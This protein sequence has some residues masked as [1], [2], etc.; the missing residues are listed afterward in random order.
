MQIKALIIFLSF[1]TYAFAADAPLFESD[2]F[3]R[4][5]N[6]TIFLSILY[7]L[8]NDIVRKFITDRTKRIA[9]RLDEV[10]DKLKASKQ[11]R[12]D[13]QLHLEQSKA[14]AVE[15][16]ENAKK[17]C[18]YIAKKIEEQSD[19]DVANLEKS[20]E[21]RQKLERSKI[22]TEVVEQVMNEL[23]QED[24]ASID[25]ETFIKLVQKKVA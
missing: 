17:E 25:Q 3:Y 4:V 5:F 23:L 9:A 16:V 14:K 11:A 21:D 6:V 8:V 20:L 24:I 10:S 19:N 18:Q 2:F 22:T 15:I 7:Y 1:T 13:A 12:K